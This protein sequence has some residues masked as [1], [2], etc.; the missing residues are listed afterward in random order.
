[1]RT[2][3]KRTIPVVAALAAFGL[4]LGSAVADD[5]P[6]R[7]ITWIV[8]WPAGGGQDTTS[9]IVADKLGEVLGVA[10]AVENHAGAG[11]LAGMRVIA[12]AEPDGYTIGMFGSSSIVQQYTH[13]DA[14]MRD[15]IEPLAFFGA[16][17]GALSVH[18]D[19]G[20]EDVA[21]LLARLEAQPRSI[22]NGNDPP[23]GASYINAA[24]L[25]TVLG[26]ELTKVPYAGY[27]PTV[28]ALLG[29]EVESA[30]V[31]VPQVIEH[32]EAG[33]VRILGVMAE[34]RHFMAP[35][36]PTFQEQG[37]DLVIGDFRAVVGPAGIPEERLKVLE[38]ALIEALTDQ[39]LIERAN[40][41]GYDVSAMDRAATRAF[42]E[43]FDEQ[44][45]PVLEAADLVEV[46]RQ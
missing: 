26:V 22:R 39:G 24:V 42:M 16:D 46:P 23:G 5:Y 6:D 9:R 3:S 27:A 40:N 41:A 36:V 15:E 43:R 44:V 17:P 10:I 20:I 8:N 34:G 18:V 38:E 4:G 21:E 31:P 1:M 12:G 30:T 11:G 29:G 37:F 28:T 32:H 2:T 25:E 13:E 45:Y 33:T 35:D 14:V 19:T 7:A